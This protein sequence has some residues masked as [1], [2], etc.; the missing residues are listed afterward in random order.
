MAR[1]VINIDIPHNF[2]PRSYQQNLF[3]FRG[4]GYDRAIAIW[5]RRAGKD[6]T[7]WNMLITE[8]FIRVGSYYYFFPTYAQGRKIIWDGIDRDSF[9]FLNHIPKEVIKSKHQTDM[10]IVLFNG[11]IVQIIG[12]DNIDR[13]VGTN[14]VGCVFSEYA[15]QDPRAWEFVRPILRENKGWAIFVSTPR[16]HNHCHELYTMAQD[17]PRWFCELLTVADTGVMNERDVEEERLAGMSEELIAQEFY[18]SFDAAMPGAYFA[19]QLKQ[20]YDEERVTEVPLAGGVA[21]D[22]WWDLGIDDSTSIILSQDVG[23]EIRIV[24]CIEDNNEPLEYFARRLEEWRKQ[25]G[26]AYGRHILPHDGANRS[27]Q[28]GKSHV[29]FLRELGVPAT[30]APRPRTKEVS[31]EQARRI[32][33][34]CWFDKKNAGRLLEALSNYRKELKQDAKEERNRIYGTRP[35]HDWSC[36][37]SDAFQVLAAGH[38]FHRP[39]RPQG[40]FRPQASSR[41]WA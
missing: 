11:S 32:F 40:R 19:S 41:G 7:V 28:T 24:G 38:R 5:H 35:V 15:L 4:K 6:K 12:T 16:G 34:S 33:R 17:N 13:I 2:V 26:I 10:K 36:H 23:R 27:L 3:T 22:T 8:A 21:V 37:L 30:A 20:A 31:I 9:P 14:P 39:R 18:C 29:Q 25:H 1:E